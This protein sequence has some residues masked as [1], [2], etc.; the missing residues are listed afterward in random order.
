[1]ST[2]NMMSFVCDACGKGTIVP[3]TEL[4]LPPVNETTAPGTATVPKGWFVV[5]VQAV[6]EWMRVWV[7]SHE[8]RRDNAVSHVCSVACV[9]QSLGVFAAKCRLVL[10]GEA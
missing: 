6:D 7:R 2:E 10:S 4:S 9:V 1:M 8:G 5:D 3:V